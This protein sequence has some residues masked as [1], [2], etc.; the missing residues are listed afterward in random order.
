ML[1]DGRIADRKD[2]LLIM[3]ICA[4]DYILPLFPIW[5]PEGIMIAEAEKM[6]G[7]KVSELRERVKRGILNPLRWGK[8][9][10][11]Q[12]A[13]EMKKFQTVL[14]KAILKR[15]YPGLRTTQITEQQMN[16]V[17]NN[18]FNRQD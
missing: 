11:I 16:L 18:V 14:K 15:L 7:L 5:D 12:L 8:D 1:R 17:L 9:D 6:S 13:Y 3:N 4:E 10:R 2:H